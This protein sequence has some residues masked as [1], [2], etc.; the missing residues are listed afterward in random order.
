MQ[1]PIPQPFSPTAPPRAKRSSALVIKDPKTGKELDFKP[2]AAASATAA[3]P[4]TPATG[5]A[6]PAKS[7]SASAKGADAAAA[8]SAEERQKKE[9][10]AAAAAKQS[11]EETRKEFQAGVL[12]RLNAEKEQKE[13]EEREAREAK[14]AEEKAQREAE[15]AAAAKKKAEEEAAAAAAE[16][17]AAKKK[18]AEEE[19]QKKKAEAEAA[20]AKK[21][22]DEEAE[23]AKKEAEAKA[24]ADA[25]A[26]A[27]AEAEAE[28]KAKAKAE[29]EAEAKKKQ[30]AEQAEATKA[31]EQKA[32]AE[33]EAKKA[34]ETAATETAKASETAAPAAP[35]APADEEDEFERMI[36]EME[37]KDK[38]DMA[39]EAAYNEK[40]RK[41]KEEAEAK[42][43]AEE[44]AFWADTKKAEAEAEAAELA[45]EKKREAERR[46]AAGLPP[47]EEKEEGKKTGGASKMFENLKAK[48]AGAAAAAASTDASA[49]P[50]PA[51]PTAAGL[52][53]KRDKPPTSLKIDAAKSVEPPQPSA[54][55]KSLQSARFLVDPFAIEYPANINPP[56]AELNASSPAGKFKYNKEFL[57]QFQAVI[58]EKPSLDWD[59]RVRETVGDSSSDGGRAMSSRGGSSRQGSRAGPPPSHHGPRAPMGAFGGSTMDPARMGAMGN[60]G[61]FM[62]GGFPGRAGSNIMPG[63]PRTGSRRGGAGGRQDSK[64]DNRHGSRREDGQK[65]NAMPLTANMEIK[66]IQVSAA[67]WK[68][69]SVGAA[70]SGPALGGEAYMTPDVVQRKV[71]AALNKMTPDNFDRIS[72]QILA[73]VAQSK[74][75]EDGR[76]LRQVIQ[77][78]FEKA[79][80]EAHWAGLYA[81]F[82][83]CMLDTMSPD[84]KDTNILDRFGNVVGGGSLFR[85]YLLTRCQA[86]FE[87]GWKSKLPPKP[88]GQEEA[89]LMS[90]EYYIAAAAKRRGLGLVKF[91]GELFKLGMLT[92]R[93]M[94]KCVHTLVDFEGIPDE[95]EVESLCNLLRTIGAQLDASEKGFRLME[96]YFERIQKMIDTP[97]LASRLRFMLMDLVDLRDKQWRSK[98]ADKGPKTLQEIREAAAREAAAHEMERAR[99]QS[100]RGGGGRMPPGRGDA[101]GYGGFHQP[102]PDNSRQVG[103][104]D[105]RRLRASRGQQSSPALFGPTTMFSRASSGRGSMGPGGN[106]LRTADSRTNSR[107]GSSAGK[108]EKEEPSRSK[109]AFDALASLNDHNDPVGSPPSRN[110]S[111]A[112]S[113]AKGASEE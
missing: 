2:A 97:G 107:A 56:S 10:A 32:A 51:K 60:M 29:A 98:D 101:R 37:E 87:V 26:K 76:T 33:A 84:I 21:K 12:A 69:R 4:T 68:P 15:A 5:E 62:G 95:A 83:K 88:E 79:T 110:D 112:M 54:A 30:E 91:I 103:N 78:T 49:M 73:I 55:L 27:K 72:G 8:E 18:A 65:D 43:K 52:A 99:Q 22:A 11:E 48:Q 89:A 40:K 46:A 42:K 38:A 16:A 6:S 28:A 13:R 92:E 113:A 86:E 7:A 44:A 104:D 94:H 75:E 35:A 77:L 109:N 80:D 74:E 61:A 57:L 64:R 41:E 9:K 90:D 106:L 19:E 1:A 93:I 63:S 31:A 82:C 58:K 36:R 59:Q 100:H 71:K 85:K 66:P 50:P 53:G 39:A 24:K 3:A 96:V 14:E 111:P 81:R 23:A 47:L 34:E 105:L 67:G 25:E 70:A 102:P 20:A 45:R 17:E 108:A